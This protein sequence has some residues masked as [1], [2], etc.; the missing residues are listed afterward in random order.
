MFDAHEADAVRVDLVGDVARGQDAAREAHLRRLLMRSADCAGAAHLARQAHLAE[1]RPCARAAGGCGRT[2]RRRRRRRGR[3]P[4][5][6]PRAR[7][8]RSRTR[9]RR[10]ARGRRAS[11]ARRGAGSCGSGR[12]RA[13]C[14][15]ACRRRSARRGPAPRR[16]SAASPRSWQTTAEP[17][18]PGLPLGE[19]ERRGVRRPAC[20]PGARHLEDAQLRDRAEA[21]LHRAHDA[22]VLA[23]LALEVEDRVHDV[24]ERL[25]AR[26]GCRPSS[27]GRSGTS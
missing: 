5:R 12:C 25:R 27:R 2:T 7:R 22:V 13:T 23:L 9:R 20:R 19:E 17:G 6:P 21:V 10:A 8:R 1:E 16:A 3:P 24:L 18:E 4:A 11:R 26:R 15:A 14:A